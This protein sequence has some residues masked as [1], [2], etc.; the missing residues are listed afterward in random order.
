MASRVYSFLNPNALG[1]GLM[2]LNG[3]RVVTTTLP[4]LDKNRKVMAT[5]PKGAG[6]AYFE[7]QFFTQTQPTATPVGMRVGVCAS[8]SSL[9]TCVGDDVYSYGY[10]CSTG[11]LY[12][13]TGFQTLASVAAERTVIGIYLS[14]AALRLTFFIGGNYIGFTTLPSGK[15][16][17]PSISVFG[18]SPGDISAYINTGQTG[19][20]NPI[21]V[22]G[23]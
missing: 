20:E 21:N 22:A 2:L 10:E 9:V 1:P 8:D 18:S 7:T 13:N 17:V 11:R 3:G 4:S 15:F 19:F 16:W 23:Y 14:V 12:N 5:L 6:D